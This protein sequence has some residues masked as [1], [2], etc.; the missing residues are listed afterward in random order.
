MPAPSGIV[1]NILGTARGVIG[2]IPLRNIQI[3][4]FA[5]DIFLNALATSNT[6]CPQTRA[7]SPDADKWMIV[8]RIIVESGLIYML[9]VLVLLISERVGI[10][11]YCV[12]DASGQLI[13]ITSILIMI[14]THNVFE[15]KSRT[16]E[17]TAVTMPR[18]AHHSNIVSTSVPFSTTGTHP[19]E[20]IGFAVSE[21]IQLD[22]QDSKDW[23]GVSPNSEALDP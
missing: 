22:I 23:D 19:E 17:P 13:A 20:H 1:V 11:V 18:F 9:S 15:H 8:I 3:G 6:A 14:R 12:G 4:M 7:T 10:L 2:P 5:G 16:A 21:F